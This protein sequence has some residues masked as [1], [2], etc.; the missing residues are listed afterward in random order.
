MPAS[1]NNPVSLRDPA[2]RVTMTCMVLAGEIVPQQG[3]PGADHWVRMVDETEIVAVFEGGG[4]GFS[5]V[6]SSIL[7]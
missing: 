5:A 3:E 7:I 2:D 1:I 6:V 4:F